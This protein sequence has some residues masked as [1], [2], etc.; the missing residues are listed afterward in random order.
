MNKERRKL[1]KK[2]NQLLLEAKDIIEDVLNDEE[3]AFDNLSE[4]LQC[5]MRG[6]QMENNIGEMEDAINNIDCV[7]DNLSMID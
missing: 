3:N 5:T 6:E 7:I 1:I 4:G 2:A